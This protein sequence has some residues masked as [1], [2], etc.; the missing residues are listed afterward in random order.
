MEEAI[1][2]AGAVRMR[3]VVM[4]AATTILGLIPLAIG[5]GNGAEMVQPVAIVC[6]GG[7]LYATATTLLV[8]P[9]MYRLIG[10][11]H[12]EKIEDEE[13]EIVTV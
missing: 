2:N 4:T 5:L 8:I 1:I 6:I 12:M 11:K 7:L 10:R 13:L 9:I 3:P